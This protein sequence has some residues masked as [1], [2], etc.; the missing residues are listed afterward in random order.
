ME[1]EASPGRWPDESAN[2]VDQPATGRH[3]LGLSADEVLTTTRAVRKR[4]DFTRPVPRAL[5]GD[6]VRIATQAPS[7]RNRQRWDFVIVD[8]PSL[9][10]EVADVWRRGLLHGGPGSGSR[11]DV[12]RMPFHSAE[13]AKIA[14]SLDHLARHLH[15]APA[16]VIPCVRV[17]SRAELDTVRGQ[18]GAWGSVLPAVWS[19]MLA[20][21]ERG[22]GTAWTTAHLDYEHD[23]ARLLGI[24]HDHVV[25]CA[26]T[27]VAFTRGTTF[28]P[29]PRADHR[30]FMHWNRWNAS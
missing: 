1:A 7:G 17:G 16:L 27:P 10:A 21:R 29:G 11:H 25:Q 9:R 20:A 2:E 12:T 28:R 5:I 22:L 14:E 4:L 19:F 30:A 8:D 23:M 3:H 15:D 13:W 24:D 6:C 18:A 26:L